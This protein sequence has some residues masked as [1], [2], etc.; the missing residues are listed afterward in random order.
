MGCSRR[1]PEESWNIAMSTPQVTISPT[2]TR[3]RP[4]ARAM[5]F[6]A[7]VCAGARVGAIDVIPAWLPRT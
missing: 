6:C 3:S 2:D 7:S 4:L 5:S 1:G